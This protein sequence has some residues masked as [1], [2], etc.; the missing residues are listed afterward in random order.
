MV[1]NNLFGRCTKSPVR[2]RSNKRRVIDE[3]IG[4]KATSDR[5]RV[6]GNVFYAF[7]DGPEMTGRDNRSDYNIFVHPPTGQ[8][9][10]LT[11]FYTKTGREAHSIT[12][13]SHMGLSPTNWTLEQT[14]TLPMLRFPRPPVVTFDFFNTSR[15]N[16][17]TEAGPFAQ[18]NLAQQTVLRK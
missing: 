5:N 11:A 6:F 3:D 15:Q 18:R 10:D 1:T 7:H 14:P 8:P 2:M 17:V 9:F 4:R 13:A 12:F 16:D